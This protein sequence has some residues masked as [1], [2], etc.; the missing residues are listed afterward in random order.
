[1]S[2]FDW[3]LP[4]LSGIAQSNVPGPVRE[5]IQRPR[6]AFIS[7]LFSSEARTI[8]RLWPRRSSPANFFLGLPVQGPLA[9]VHI[10]NPMN[11]SDSVVMSGPT[12]G[13]TV[14]RRCCFRTNRVQPDGTNRCMNAGT[15]FVGFTNLASSGALACTRHRALAR[16]YN[17]MNMSW[18]HERPRQPLENAR[19]SDGR[20]LGDTSEPVAPPGFEV[21]MITLFTDEFLDQH[22]IDWHL[23]ESGTTCPICLDEDTDTNPSHLC[24]QCGHGMHLCC[25]AQFVVSGTVDLNSDTVPCPLCRADILPDIVRYRYH[26]LHKTVCKPQQGGSH[27]LRDFAVVAEGENGSGIDEEIRAFCVYPG[28]VTFVSSK[29]PSVL[30]QNW[31]ELGIQNMSDPTDQIIDM[32]RPLAPS[33]PPVQPQPP[34]MQTPPRLISLVDSPPPAPRVDRRVR[35]R[36][37]PTQPAHGSEDPP[38]PRPRHVALLARQPARIVDMGSSRA[39]GVNLTQIDQDMSTSRQPYVYEYAGHSLSRNV[40]FSLTVTDVLM[41]GSFTPQ[42]QLNLVIEDIQPAI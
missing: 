34:G 19:G 20:F 21:A 32:V 31:S 27:T 35:R 24:L 9:G 42:R 1:M 23:T 28:P 16:R 26:L 18:T 8:P 29:N 17:E 11:S 22:P 39:I 30:A 3:F 25:M 33:S 7:S 14:T 37:D 36:L 4:G 41:P 2:A 6:R 38:Y 10:L 15:T 40:Q 5:I 12:P 13:R